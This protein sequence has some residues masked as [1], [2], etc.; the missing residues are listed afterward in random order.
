MKARRPFS[1]KMYNS[2][3]NP[4]EKSEKLHLEVVSRT[5]LIH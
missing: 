1:Q 3:V 4:S 2:P 5:S